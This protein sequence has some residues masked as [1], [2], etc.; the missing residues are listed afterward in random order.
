MGGR[1]R[2]GLRRIT[3]RGKWKIVAADSSSRST[4]D[5]YGTPVPLLYVVANAGSSA[6]PGLDGSRARSGGSAYAWKGV[7][8]VGPW[9]AKGAVISCC[10]AGRAVGARLVSWY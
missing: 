9:P 2:S 1:L 8:R 6:K 10:S 4:E 3:T 5:P 7:G